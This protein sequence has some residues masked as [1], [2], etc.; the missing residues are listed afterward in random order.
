MLP[1]EGG[2]LFFF[3]EVS[4]DY[5][6]KN[7]YYDCLLPVD[8]REMLRAMKEKGTDSISRPLRLLPDDSI[9][10]RRII[11][12][13][14]ENKFAQAPFVLKGPGDLLK[15]TAAGLK[16]KSLKMP[17]VPRRGNA[18]LTFGDF[19]N[20]GYLYATMQDGR[21][22]VAIFESL[23]S[24]SISRTEHV[25]SGD[26]ASEM[27]V[28]TMTAEFN[29]LNIGKVSI[30]FAVKEVVMGSDSSASTIRAVFASESFPVDL[31]LP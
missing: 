27:P 3:C 28:S 11:E 6:E 26:F 1:S 23:A 29:T 18:G 8:L 2:I 20:G 15:L 10:L 13:F 24:L 22:A 5:R 31:C 21:K 17:K 7:L 25:T 9:E 12:E 30:S 16:I 19:S 4:E 14:L